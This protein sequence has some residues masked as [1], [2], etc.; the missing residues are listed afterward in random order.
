MSNESGANRIYV[1]SFPSGVG[2]FQISTTLG[3][4]PRW[5]RD[6]KEIYYTGPQGIMAVEVKTSP[7]FERGV[8]KPIGSPEFYQQFIYNVPFRY[9]VTADGKR[10]LLIAPV[11]KAAAAPITVVLNWQAALKN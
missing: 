9:D 2:K 8:P 5:R 11:A 4:E 1:Q 6:G 3:N 7:K 10:F